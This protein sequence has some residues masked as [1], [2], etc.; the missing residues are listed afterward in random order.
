M[1]GGRVEVASHAVD[2]GIPLET[3]FILT[4]FGDKDFISTKSIDG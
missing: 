3:V 4:T 2:L 1:L